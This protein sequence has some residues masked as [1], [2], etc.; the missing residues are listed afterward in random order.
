[1]L[2]MYTN[3]ERIGGNF[4]AVNQRNLALL[5][6]GEMTNW[7]ASTRLYLVSERDFI[8]R[9]FGDESDEVRRFDKATSQAF[10]AYVG[11]RFLYNLRDYAQHC[12]PPVSGI[13][14]SGDSASRRKIEI[15]LSRSELLVA[16]FNWSSHARKLLE[17]W[18][19]QISVLP[20]VEEAMAGFHIIEN[21][22]LRILLVRC[23][24]ATA[25]MR[26]GIERVA[27]AEGHPAVFQLPESKEDGRFTW[28]TFPE[29][30]ALDAIDEALASAD[31]LEGL[32]KEPSGAPELPPPQRY[33][34][35]R[36]AAV[37]AARLED[38]NGETFA[39]TVNRV[40]QEDQGITPLISG[41]GN[42]S[43]ILVKMLGQALG[44]PPQ[45]LLGSFS[46]PQ[47]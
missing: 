43:L 28:K 3:I 9:Q 34:N 4:R 27:S 19:E 7:L 45:D 10:D 24:A 38:E 22:V 15:Y 37:I 11:Y 42:V 21:E 2:E 23:G 32:R 18:P 29:L 33:A 14:I 25:E 39:E 8:L 6:M 17:G 1:M 44:T 5:F 12:G 20:L 13:A 26:E 31:P 41:L 46:D 16:H 47:P 36:A 35:S 30:S 40:I